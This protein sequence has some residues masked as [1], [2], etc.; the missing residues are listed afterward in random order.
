MTLHAL[1]AYRLAKG[2]S[3]AA[4]ARKVGVHRITVTRWELGVQQIDPDQLAKIAR[5]TGIP[6]AL[7]RPDLA[8]VFG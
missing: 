5:V 8:K 7:L 6:A 1:R 4:L 3:Q 2:L